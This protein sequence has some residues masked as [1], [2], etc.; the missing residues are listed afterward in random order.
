MGV[1]LFL[2][3]DV[4]RCS[5][6]IWRYVWIPALVHD[7]AGMYGGCAAHEFTSFRQ[8]EVTFD[9]VSYIMCFQDSLYTSA[10]GVCVKPG[11]RP[12]MSKYVNAF[13]VELSNS[14]DT[15]G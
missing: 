14:F 3:E 7:G 4:L 13:L 6:V 12:L 8:S 15:G 1:K 5:K 2:E 10:N 9:D 11:C